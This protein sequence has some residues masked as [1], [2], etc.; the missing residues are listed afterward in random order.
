MPEEFQRMTFDVEG[1]RGWRVL[2]SRLTLLA[3]MAI[4]CKKNEAL[5]NTRRTHERI[6]LM[7]RVIFPL[8]R[9]MTT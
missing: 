5:L 7:V 6:N 2:S 8:A 1:A 3:K 4:R 9:V